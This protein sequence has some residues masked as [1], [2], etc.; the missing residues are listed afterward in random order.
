MQVV[1][2]GKVHHHQSAGVLE[3]D[4]VAKPLTG[5]KQR[6]PHEALEQLLEQPH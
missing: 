5:W 1:L 2:L 3:S 4:Q 6:S